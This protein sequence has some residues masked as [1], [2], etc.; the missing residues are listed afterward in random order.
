MADNIKKIIKQYW[1]I[2]VIFIILLIKGWLVSQLS[3][4][5]RDSSGV[6]Q[7]KM[8]RKAEDI[9]NGNYWE[10]YSTETMFK[11][12]VLF[13]IFLAFCHVCNVPYLTGYTV[14]YS[15]SCL[16]ALYSFSKFCHDKVILLLSFAVIMFSPVSYDITVQFV[17]NKGFVA[18]LEVGMIACLML[19]FFYRVNLKKFLLWNLI[20]GIYLLFLWMDREDTQWSLVLLAGYVLITLLSIGY[21]NFFSRKG[22][23]Y[24]GCCMLPVIILAVGNMTLC[25]LN[26]IHYGIWV[27]NDHI[28]TGFADA[29]NSILKIVPDSYPESCSIT[30]DMLEKAM[31]VSPALKEVKEFIDNEYENGSFLTVGRAPDDGEIED[32]WMPFVLRNAAAKA[33]YYKNAVITDQYWK[34]VSNEIEEAFKNEILEERDI[35]LFG[36]MLKHPWIKKQ[37]YFE[38]WMTSWW[39]ILK[40][41]FLHNLTFP[42]L[43]YSTIDSAIIKRYE[44]LT[45]E[46]AIEEP[47]KSMHLAGW[48]L[49]EDNS[50]FEGR[51][52]NGAGK[53]LLE[54]QWQQEEVFRNFEND[55]DNKIVPKRFLVDFNYCAQDKLYFVLYT[56]NDILEKI[57]LIRGGEIQSNKIQGNFEEFDVKTIFT[58]PSEKY[59]K[60]KVNRAEKVAIIYQKISIIFVLGSAIIYSVLCINMISNAIKKRKNE[61]YE[62]WVYMTAILGSIVVYTGALAYIDAFMFGGIWYSS[63]VTGLVDLLWSVSIIV[64]VSMVHKCC[65]EK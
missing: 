30:H 28:D 54:I 60:S 15:I 36:S 29:Y 22:I 21:K 58:D 49:A 31:S 6:D 20:G 27:T 23:K 1:F 11:R 8:L 17:Y 10:A 24:I 52:E 13:P 51:I 5:A 63:P 59:T 26:F 39:K 38:R 53:V 61:F 62:L 37:N 19:A 64:I 3:I 46:N 43:Q 44:A 14:V 65:R 50:D 16:L 32:G 4:Y 33:G 41:N 48:L 40:S 12:D 7:W 2:I 47:I 25:T 42:A 34:T 9:I 18:P 35:F 57:D 56:E 45:Y 55:Q